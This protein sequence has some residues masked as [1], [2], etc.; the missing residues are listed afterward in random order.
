[1]A[2]GVTIQS[3]SAYALLQEEFSQG[4]NTI[5][6]TDTFFYNMLPTAS[7]L[8]FAGKHAIHAMNFQ[9][10][11]SSGYAGQVPASYPTPGSIRP[12]TITI[13]Q[14]VNLA[15]IR[16][17]KT[18]I[19]KTNKA[20]FAKVWTEAY[21]STLEHMS[22]EKERISLGNGS[23]ILTTHGP[24][25]R[26]SGALA[27]TAANWTFNISIFDALKIRAGMQIEFWR[28]K[29][30]AA[31]TNSIVANQLY[32]RHATKLDTPS[33]GFY[34]VASVAPD[35][36]ARTATVTIAEASPGTNPPA[37]GATFSAFATAS[38]FDHIVIAGAILENGNTTNL[39]R[40]PYGIDAIACGANGLASTSGQ[41]E[42]GNAWLQQ[43]V[44]ANVLSDDTMFGL[45][46]STVPEHSALV[47]DAS[48][49]GTVST[50]LDRAHMAKMAALLNLWAANGNFRQS[51]SY[52]GHPAQ[53]N[54]YAQKLE[55]AERYTIASTTPSELPAGRASL[56]S[57]SGQGPFLMYAG[58]PFYGSSY[59]RADR[60]YIFNPRGMEKNLT[61]PFAFDSTHPDFG[62]RPAVQMDGMGMDA[63][64]TRDRRCLG[65]I[66]NLALPSLV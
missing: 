41:Y 26:V 7:D 36:S 59:C 4:V 62:G 66:H 37:A 11:S 18:A 34:T 19:T 51:Q 65:A 14:C 27:P 1:M 24:I 16:V 57:K 39:G 40:E 20:S 47:L 55:P 31:M 48:V 49:G 54:E 45:S 43:D 23:C 33:Q 46:V 9:R 56:E 50:T 30:D 22:N 25:A 58:K 21:E 42:T 8:S 35:F 13:P 17:D 64:A 12:R 5:I 61:E 53:I 38:N 28:G 2:S 32:W 29:D 10:N 63:I 52:I 60:L 6:P 44:A 15:T 3:D